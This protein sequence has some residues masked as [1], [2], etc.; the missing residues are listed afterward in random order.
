M[1]LYHLTLSKN[2][3]V[4][5]P[6]APKLVYKNLQSPDKAEDPLSQ[7]SPRIV[8]GA[9]YNS[10]FVENISL[11]WC[12]CHLLNSADNLRQR[13]RSSSQHKS[14]REKFQCSECNSSF[15]RKSDL[16]RHMRIHTGEKFQCLECNCSYREKFQ[17][18]ECNRAFTQKSVLMQHMRIHTGEK[19]QCL[20][21]SGSTHFID[22]SREG[23]K[24]EPVDSQPSILGISEDSLKLE[25]VPPSSI[26]LE[27]LKEEFDFVEE[28]F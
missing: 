1:L 3:V 20:E 11:S 17:C 15:T 18:S 6:E 8:Q 24:E 23:V 4:S 25:M 10:R 9:G 26:K 14:E 7:V 19:F 21:L 22:W 2:L 28:E 12:S 27:N 16:V 5:H 13:V